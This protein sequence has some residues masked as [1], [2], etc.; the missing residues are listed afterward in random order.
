[1]VYFSLGQAITFTARAV[2]QGEV[3]YITFKEEVPAL[4]AWGCSREEAECNLKKRFAAFV[5]EQ[6]NIG[7]LREELAVVWL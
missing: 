4:M 7:K 5:T 1:M 6:R 3:G 2:R